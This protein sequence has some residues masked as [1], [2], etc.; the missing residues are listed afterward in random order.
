MDTVVFAQTGGVLF[1]TDQRAALESYIRGGG[2]YMG[3]HYAGWSVG[4]SEHDVNP[5]YLKPRRRD[6]RGPPG[7]PGRPLGPHRRE[8]PRATR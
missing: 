2:G 3:M 4:Q 1:N 8:G 5:F 6:V 7:E